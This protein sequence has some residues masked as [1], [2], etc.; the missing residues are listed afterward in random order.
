MSTTTLDLA[1]HR[2][3]IGILAHRYG[4]HLPGC[5]SVEDLEQVG[6]L[7]L[8]RCQ[9]QHRP[10]LGSL[11]TYA[12]RRLAGAMQDERRRLDPRTLWAQRQGVPPCTVVPLRDGH[13]PATP[14]ATPEPWLAALV[15]R[16]PARLQQVLRLSYVEGWTLRE[17][18]AELG[19]SKKWTCQQ[20]QQALARL[21]ALL[22]AL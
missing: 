10:A 13:V 5:A 9:E 3:Q 15:A 19:W 11:K 2:R 18:A 12:E 21:R 6:W 22:E 14:A 7:A 8:L 1:T 16:L 4:S 17:I 20:R